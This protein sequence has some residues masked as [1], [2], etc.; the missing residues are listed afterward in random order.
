MDAAK[1]AYR[2]R[3]YAEAATLFEEAARS[4]PADALAAH[5]NRASALLE[6]QRF[7]EAAGAAKAALGL[8]G[9]S[10]KAHYRYANLHG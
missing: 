1:V 4:C 5:N 10:V 8:D 9:A 3:Q 7:S 2:S 6:L